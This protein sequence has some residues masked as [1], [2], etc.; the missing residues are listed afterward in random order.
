MRTP[1]TLGGIT[2][3]RRSV[4]PYVHEGRGRAHLAQY[5]LPVC[6]PEVL[7]LGTVPARVTAGA[8][9][10]ES[11]RLLLKNK[12]GATDLPCL[13]SD[14]RN[15]GVRAPLHL[16]RSRSRFLRHSRQLRRP[17]LLPGRFVLPPLPRPPASNAPDGTHLLLASCLMARASLGGS[18]T[19]STTAAKLGSKKNG[20]ERRSR[21]VVFLTRWGVDLQVWGEEGF[22]PTHAHKN[23]PL[24]QA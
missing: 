13:M 18:G 2:P 6:A 10:E 19:G 22:I 14:D 12:R 20:N 11:G 4:P 23:L 3:G 5:V 17:S 7:H 16:P 24:P 1:G 9:R 8:R 21:P 15:N